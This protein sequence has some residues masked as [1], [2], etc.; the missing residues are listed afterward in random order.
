MCV[1]GGGG[2]AAGSASQQATNSILDHIAVMYEPLF[3][4]I[5]VSVKKI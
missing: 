2:S 1:G 5:N 4:L 3:K